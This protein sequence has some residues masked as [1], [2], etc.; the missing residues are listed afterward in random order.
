MY[1]E[2]LGRSEQLQVDTQLNF[3]ISVDPPTAAE[4]ANLTIA[5]NRL[6]QSTWLTL[7]AS[8]HERAAPHPIAALSSAVRD[9][10]A[11]LKRGVMCATLMLLAVIGL[12]YMQLYEEIV[13]QGC[14]FM[15]A[16]LGLG[17]MF[18][19]SLALWRTPISMGARF[20]GYRLFPTDILQLTRTALTIFPHVHL[21]SA[22]IIRTPRWWLL[23]LR[24]LDGRLI[25][26]PYGTLV[27]AQRELAAIA[28]VR[29]TAAG[30]VHGSRYF[31]LVRCVCGCSQERGG[32][33]RTACCAANT[34]GPQRAVRYCGAVGCCSHLRPLGVA[35]RACRQ[36][37]VQCHRTWQLMQL[38]HN[39]H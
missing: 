34:Q 13:Y 30:E 28:N 10:R 33:H 18:T 38:L 25:A 35:Q 27:H 2:V 20:A 11:A 6:P 31:G 23:E 4:A 17:A 16:Y 8:L 36:K 22:S 1:R 14:G 37:N 5:W 26:L 29:E 9:S 39:W 12:I 19:G 32:P 7:D 3:D 21:R 24:Y 15:L